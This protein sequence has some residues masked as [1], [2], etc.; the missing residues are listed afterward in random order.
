MEFE[1]SARERQLIELVKEAQ[2]RAENGVSGLSPTVLAVHGLTGPR[3]KHFLNNVCGLPGASYLEVGVWKGAT[4]TAALYDN[5]GLKQA[6]AIDSWSELGGPIQEFQDNCARLIPGLP[7]SFYKHDAFTVPKEGLFASPVDIYF[8]DA[9][10]TEIAQEQAFTYF[11]TL[12]APSFIA[13]VDDWMWPAVQRGTRKA[14]AA[15]GYTIL[16]EKELLAPPGGD[17]NGW[18]KGLY[19]AV[20]RKA[21]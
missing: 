12:F 13:I 4:F 11:D 18:W 17:R 9:R 21:G 10:H 20:I 3:I 1:F 15:L 6:V 16:Y 2:K 8:Y 19:V 14:F 5:F 7:Y